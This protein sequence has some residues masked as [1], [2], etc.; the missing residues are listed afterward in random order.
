MNILRSIY[1][2]DR[3]V[4]TTREMAVLANTSLSSAT[5]SLKRLEEKGIIQKIIQGVWGLTADKRFSPYLVIP[6]LNQQHR[7]YLSFISALHNHGVISQIPQIITVAGTAHSRIIKTPVGMF[8]VHQISPGFFDGF[9]WHGSGDYLIAEPEKAFV[10]CLYLSSRKGRS[11]SHFPELDLSRFDMKKV[12]N[13][14]EKISNNKIR[15]SV[16]AKIKAIFRD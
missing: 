5:Q 3:L 8:H 7:S 2:I 12:K 1:K 14:V 6:F 13:W 9:G 16:L 10:D 11:Y 15:Q 4:F